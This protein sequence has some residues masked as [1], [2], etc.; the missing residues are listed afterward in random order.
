MSG[1]QTSSKESLIDTYLDE[2]WLERGLSENTLSAYRH[3]LAQLGTWLEGRSFP[4]AGRGSLPDA[5]REDILAY[6]ADRH[7]R[8]FSPRSTARQLS[9]IRGFYRFL[10]ARHLISDDPTMRLESPRLGRPLPGALSEAEVEALLAIPAPDTALGLRD[11]AML[12]TLYATGVR[13]SELVGL[14]LSRVN[15]RQGAVRVVGKGGKERLVPLGEE[16]LGWIRR[17]LEHARPALSRAGEGSDTLFLS[18]RGHAMT[19]QAFWYRVKHC[20]RAA[21]IRRAVS[22]HSLRHAFATHLLNHGAD[23]RV[24]QLLLGH[25]DLSTTQIYTH[26]A[27]AR[28]KELH[29]RHHPRA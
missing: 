15:Q 5:G 13:V 1:V 16:A 11:R 24:V 2:V 10:V 17:Y 21:G 26:V 8:G 3:D 22:P 29:R 20:A 4:D 27:R 18:N 6:L 14:T 23:L 9:C 7:R 28:L 25:A 12:E 19:R